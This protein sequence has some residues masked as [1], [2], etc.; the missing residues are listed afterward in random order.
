MATSKTMN[1][2]R[3]A[4]FWSQW[5]TDW[6]QVGPP[7]L[8]VTE[9]NASHALDYYRFWSESWVAFAAFQARLIREHGDPARFITRHC[10]G[11]FPDLDYHKLSEPL[12]LITWDSYPTGYAETTAPLLYTPGESRTPPMLGIHMS[13]G[14]AMPSRAE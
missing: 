10:I 1:E 6:E 11:T 12:D 3:G 5:Y 13:Q 7:M 9:Q 4:A 2:G 8:A 14:S